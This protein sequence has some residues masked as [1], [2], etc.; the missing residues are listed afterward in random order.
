VARGVDSVGAATRA[1]DAAAVSHGVVLHTV[2]GALLSPLLLDGHLSYSGHGDALFTPAPNSLA[3]IL[4]LGD[5][6][7]PDERADRHGGA[8]DG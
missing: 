2:G 3:S 1:V 6:R 5:D 8:D 4:L 7:A